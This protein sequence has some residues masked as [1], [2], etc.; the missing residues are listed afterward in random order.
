MQLTII[1]SEVDFHRA[2]TDEKSKKLLKCEIDQKEYPPRFKYEVFDKTGSREYFKIQR[3]LTY[4]IIGG[5]HG[6]T[7][8]ISD[9]ILVPLCPGE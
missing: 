9:K 1:Q 4:T 7:T 3:L 8:D 2:Y 6:A 5:N